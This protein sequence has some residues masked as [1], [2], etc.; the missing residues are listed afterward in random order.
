MAHNC[1]KNYNTMRQSDKIIEIS[2]NVVYYRDYI[3]PGLPELS[4]SRPVL[5]QGLVVIHAFF[6]RNLDQHLVLKVS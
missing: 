4:S 1:M 6:I 5:D 3:I 2:E